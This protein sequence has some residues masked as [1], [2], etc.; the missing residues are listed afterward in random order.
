MRN[1][2]RFSRK[3]TVCAFCIKNSGA[4]W[5]L[6]I[7]DSDT[8]WYGEPKLFSSKVSCVCILHKEFRSGLTFENF[9]QWHDL[10]WR[11][12]KNSRRLCRGRYSQKSVGFW[13]D[14]VFVFLRILKLVV[15]LLNTQFLKSPGMGLT[16][17]SRLLKIICLFCKRALWTRWYSA[18]ETCNFKEPT[19]RSHPICSTWS[20]FIVKQELTFQSVMIYICE[21][22]VEM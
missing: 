22:D 2:H 4:E 3:S 10:V 12:M 1:S 14:Y 15:L 18:K 9:W 11:G 16:T 8:T 6:R 20:V 13:N 5:F 21:C 7:S 19:N 17:T